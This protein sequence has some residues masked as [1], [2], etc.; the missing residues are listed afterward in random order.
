MPP[1]Y[2]VTAVRLGMINSDRSESLYGSPK[3]TRVDI[4]VF[5][6]AIEGNNQRILV[7]TGLRDPERWS[8]VNHHSVAPEEALEVALGNLGWKLKD[9]DIVINTHLHYDHCGNNLAFPEAQMFVS[10]AEWEFAA[11]PS[12][13][14]TPTYDLDWTSPEL[15][16]LNYALINH[17]DWDVVRGVRIIQTPGHTPGHQSVIV[18]TD[19]GLL[20]ITGDAA[21]MLDNFRLGTP[22]GNFTSAP[23]AVR[24]LQKIHNRA[25]RVLISHEP[26]IKPY[27]NSDFPLVPALPPESRMTI[28]KVSLGE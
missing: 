12:S 16:Y 8:S 6:A 21:N 10:R 3:G 9:V 19:E 25:D 14:Q 20:C 13:A 17:D 15:T 11:N 7:D 26:S 28:Q 24:S 27:Q 4:P 1:A 18:T 2:T 5:C 23:V 22:P